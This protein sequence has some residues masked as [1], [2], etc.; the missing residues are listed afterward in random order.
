ME[1]EIEDISEQTYAVIRRT[2]AFA[3]IPAVMPELMA[4]VQSWA[5]MVPHG[6]HMCIS[7]TTPDGRLSIAP[8]VQVE[9]GSAM[10]PEGFDL[11]TRPAQRSA[12]HL[13]VGGY[14]GLPGVYQELYDQLQRDGHTEVGEPIEIYE[15]HDPVP[16]TR[17]IWPIA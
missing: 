14:E 8:G 2:V 17:I 7:S 12:V 9:P 11:V 6:V 4:R 3:D 13:Y 16:E 5:D 10:P 15:K 1:Y